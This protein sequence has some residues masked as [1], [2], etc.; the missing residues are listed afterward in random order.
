MENLNESRYSLLR[1]ILFLLIIFVSVNLLGV[2]VFKLDVD[3]LNSFSAVFI[4]IILEA[5]PFILLGSFIS[6]VIQVF[7]SDATIKRLIPKNRIVAIFTASLLG[8]FIPICEC[9]II[10]VV[11]RLIKKGVPS[12]VAI[13]FMLSCPIINP[14][15]I[16]ST[17]NAF[18]DMKYMV[19]LRVGFGILISVLI[20][21]LLWY[22][23][24]DKNVLNNT[25][26]H[27]HCS[28]GHSHHYS[29]RLY[30]ILDH[31]SHEFL[32]IGKFL[33][34][35]AFISSI[36]QTSNVRSVIANYSSDSFL[37]VMAMGI[38]AYVIS[39]CSEAD[40]FIAR[41]FVQQFTVGSLVTF[42]ILGPM[43]DIKN[44]LILLSSFKKRFALEL[45]LLI[46]LLCI[47]FGTFINTSMLLR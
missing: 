43:I 14:V 17:Y 1:L 6:A 32:D 8:L 45:I 42:L 47:L 22:L 23:E 29:S 25:F 15:V 4:S 21:L 41:T 10:P 30:E 33:I 40:A 38:F 46:F 36:M 13:T 31:T 16:L 44:T 39:L 7:V 37:S 19:A 9:G 35:G 11:R 2:R 5:I 12:Y 34:F 20:G 26:E 18:Y 28:C 3:Y 27:N 24:G